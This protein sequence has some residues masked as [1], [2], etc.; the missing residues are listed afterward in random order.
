[1]TLN[2]LPTIPEAENGLILKIEA[3]DME[4]LVL[5]IQKLR[6]NPNILNAQ[7]LSIGED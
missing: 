5:L 1:M 7:T 3:K 2:T 6:E 4:S